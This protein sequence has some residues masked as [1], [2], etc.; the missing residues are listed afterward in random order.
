MDGPFVAALPSDAEVAVRVPG[1]VGVAHARRRVSAW[2]RVFVALGLIAPVTYV[3]VMV[4]RYGVNVWF[5]DQWQFTPI[6]RSYQEHALT[7][8][9]LW[10]R[11]NEHRIFFP[12]LLMLALALPTRG[13]VFAP[14]AASI[15]L[16][17]LSLGLLWTVIR[18]T[19][20]DR[21]LAYVALV[22][23]S[24]LLFS[25]VQ[26]ESWLWGWNVSWFLSNA[27]LF[28]AIWALWSWQAR[29][30]WH[31]YTV[32]AVAATVATFSLASG[33]FV[34]V[35]GLILIAATPSLRRLT[36]A[37]LVA[38]TLVVGVNMI[39]YHASVFNLPGHRPPTALDHLNYLLVNLTRPMSPTF[40]I[41]FAQFFSAIYLVVVVAVVV[42]AARRRDGEVVNRLLPWL[43]LLAF[44]VLNAA[45][46]STSRVALGIDQAYASRYTTVSLLGVLA[47]MVMLLR[48]AEV[49]RR[50]GAA[51]LAR[52]GA[53]AVI[54][55]V[56]TGMGLSVPVDVHWSSV[57]HQ[58]LL[59]VRDCA[60]HAT[61]PAD[62]C[63][64]HVYPDTAL[65]WEWIQYHRGIGWVAGGG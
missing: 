49:N 58:E 59:M 23:A 43:G 60:E 39:G 7:F 37:W 46:M 29:S 32:A 55:A 8:G 50:G 35:V 21:R 52:V 24:I 27:G 16:V 13:N 56:L 12:S 38:G 40:N 33:T 11:H 62:P 30:L 20:D 14:I 22:L 34:W 15:V 9:E 42:S 4:A 54:V 1:D 10:A 17:A 61:G 48:T 26:W 31:R 47:G 19:F 45:A 5:W 41:G 6:I 65:A 57:Q 25:P 28:V 2:W 36:A 64:G 63:L 18:R 53:A 3:V 44:A 51:V